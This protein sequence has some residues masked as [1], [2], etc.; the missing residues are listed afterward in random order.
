[1]CVSVHNYKAVSYK[2]TFAK[3]SLHV[4][5]ENIRENIN[6]NSNLFLIMTLHISLFKMGQEKQLTL[7]NYFQDSSNYL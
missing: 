5:L 6:S 4:L 2:K 3:P 7:T 1:M